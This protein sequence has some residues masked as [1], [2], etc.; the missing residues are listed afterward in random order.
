MSAKVVLVM[1][2]QVVLTVMVPIH[3]IALRD[4]KEMEQFAQVFR[5]VSVA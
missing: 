4:M 1:I 3:A 2:T 5:I